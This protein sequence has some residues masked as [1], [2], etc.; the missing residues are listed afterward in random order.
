[1]LQIEPFTAFASR[2]PDTLLIDFMR[3][4]IG[5][6]GVYLIVNLALS[7]VLAAQKIRS[8]KPPLRQI[9]SEIATSLRTVLI[10][11]AFGTLVGIGAEAGV[12]PIYLDIEA[13]GWPWLIA[14]TLLII[15]AHDAWFYWSHWL[16]H[17]PQLY[18]RFH[19]RH[20]LSHNPTPFTSYSFDVAEAVVNAAFF[21]LVLL[22]IPAHPF[23][24][25]AFTSHMMLRN[26]LGHC[27]YELF[28]ATNNGL[29]RFDWMTTVTHHD[30]HHA[31]ARYN[32]GLYFTWWDRWMGTEHPEYHARFAAASGGLR[33]TGAT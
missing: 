28:P 25:L 1:M 3:Y 8:Q 27:G 23:A 26:A 24:L 10:F 12:M 32:L 11:A 21:P 16:M 2:Y 33:K 4:V 6:G 13:Y 22:I 29:P 17:R 7:G 20:H 18:R 9:G 5:A 15:L 19:R 31:N 30:L 14:S